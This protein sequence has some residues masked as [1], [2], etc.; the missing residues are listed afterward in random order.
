MGRALSFILGLAI[1]S[2][3]AALADARS[4]DGYRLL[5]HPSNRIEKV[6]KRFLTQVFLKKVTR[7]P[8]NEAIRPVDLSAASEVRRQFVEDVMNRSIGSVINYWQQQIFSGRNVP[9]PELESERAV[10]EFVL[11]HPGAVGYV[12]AAA[13]V[14]AAKVVVVE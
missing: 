2:A 8:D 4:A 12:S 5:V 10:V 11:S 1:M 13:N 6:E 9:P 3:T 7:W 14:G